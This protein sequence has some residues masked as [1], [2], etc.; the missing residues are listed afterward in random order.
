M[1][2]WLDRIWIS[3]RNCWIIFAFRGLDTMPRLTR[4]WRRGKTTRCYR[5]HLCRK[6]CSTEGWKTPR[7]FWAWWWT[8]EFQM[9]RSLQISLESS[10]LTDCP[11]TAPQKKG[12]RLND[13]GLTQL[14]NETRKWQIMRSSKLH[15]RFVKS[16]LPPKC[17][18]CSMPLSSFGTKHFLALQNS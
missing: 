7:L 18:P 14:R 1:R 13:T 5:L 9:Q 8:R 3:V 17:V 6:R 16:N 15:V 12:D 4:T 2:S 11:T 10:L